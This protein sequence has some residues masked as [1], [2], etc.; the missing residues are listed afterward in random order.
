[1]ALLIGAIVF[2][3]GLLLFGVVPTLTVAGWLLLGLLTIVLVGLML[4]KSGWL[5]MVAAWAVIW[6]PAV[7]VAIVLLIDSHDRTFLN[8]RAVV[9]SLAALGA[10][11]I[12]F[13]MVKAGVEVGWDA[14]KR[15]RG[16]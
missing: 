4:D 9:L 2:L 8:I 7:A 15:R 3:A 6:I 10:L 16:L 12:A 11:I 1:M 14:W 5:P 13:A